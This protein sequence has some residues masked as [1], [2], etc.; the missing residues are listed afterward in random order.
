[1]QVFTKRQIVSR[2][3][4]GAIGTLFVFILYR[5]DILRAIV[6][7]AIFAIG[8]I[9]ILMLPKYAAILSGISVFILLTVTNIYGNYVSVERLLVNAG[10]AL[11]GGSTI[12]AM[13]KYGYIALVIPLLF[14]LIGFAFFVWVL[15]RA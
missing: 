13:R 6:Q 5:D 11:M 7:A 1:M 12:W 10:I 4:L 3:I 8:L 15:V 9:L 2:A 14:V